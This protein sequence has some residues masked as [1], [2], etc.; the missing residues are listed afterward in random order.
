MKRP[1]TVK[2]LF[3]SSCKPSPNQ[4]LMID[5]GTYDDIER[6]VSI[7]EVYAAVFLVTISIIGFRV[8]FSLLRYLF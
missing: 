7:L 6:Y 2:Y 4:R 5:R 8:C 1:E 3:S